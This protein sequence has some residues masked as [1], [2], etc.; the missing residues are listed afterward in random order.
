MPAYKSLIVWV[1][2]VQ[3]K[4]VNRLQRQ[5]EGLLSNYHI[6]E[7]AR[8]DGWGVVEPVLQF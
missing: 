8:H 5:L 2:A 3:E 6:L 4:V 7:Q 1:N